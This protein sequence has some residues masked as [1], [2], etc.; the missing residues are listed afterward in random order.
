MRGFQPVHSYK[1][2]LSCA[3]LGMQL[4][5]FYLLWEIGEIVSYSH[6]KKQQNFGS[7]SNCRYCTDRGKNLPGPASNVWLTLFQISFKSVHF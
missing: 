6:D 7:I 3:L 1:D 5:L 4:Y 2:Q